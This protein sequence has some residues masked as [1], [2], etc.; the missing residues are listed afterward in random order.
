MF[1]VCFELWNVIHKCLISWGNRTPGVKP[2][3]H[4]LTTVSFLITASS[5][6]VEKT[7]FNNSQGYVGK[8]LHGIVI[9]SDQK[10]K[11]KKQKRLESDITFWIDLFPME[12]N[13]KLFGS[14][15]NWSKSCIPSIW[16]ERC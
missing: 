2:N 6:L 14:Q 3:F 1:W 13:K 4:F 7:P 11:V 12:T 5:I 15:S 8:K 16:Q 10:V 9:T